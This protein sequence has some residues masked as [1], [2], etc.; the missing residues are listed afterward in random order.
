MSSMGARE[1]TASVIDPYDKLG[2]LLLNWIIRVI[3]V[4]IELEQ[5]MHASIT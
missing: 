4:K 2:N 1:S 3:L 5:L